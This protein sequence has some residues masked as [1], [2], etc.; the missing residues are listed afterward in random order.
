[1]GFHP[2]LEAP[3][4]QGAGDDFTGD[5]EVVGEMLMNGDLSGKW[6]AWSLL[7]HLGH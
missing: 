4:I 7:T 3:A 5:A 1:M 2:T 6:R